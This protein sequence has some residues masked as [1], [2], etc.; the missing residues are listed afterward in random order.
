[1]WDQQAQN[2]FE[3]LLN[4]WRAGYRRLLLIY[5]GY[6]H[7]GKWKL[8]YAAALL[9]PDPVTVGVP[10]DIRISTKSLMAGRLFLDCVELD[11]HP[12]L[13][14]LVRGTL[15]ID[16]KH[17]ELAGAGPNDHSLNLFL[18]GPPNIPSQNV[19]MPTLVIRS[20]ATSGLANDLHIADV[21]NDLR[22]SD[23]PFDGFEDL[24]SSLGFPADVRNSG[25]QR[26][27]IFLGLAVV[28]TLPD[29]RIADSKAYIRLLASP[30]ITKTRV[31][32]GIRFSDGAN[33]ARRIAIA[34]DQLAW[35]TMDQWLEGTVNIP[36]GNTPYVQCL[37]QYG[38][39]HVSRWWLTDPSQHL[40]FRTAIQRAFDP[41]DRKLTKLLFPP[42]TESRDLEKGLALLM[43]IHGFG[44]LQ[45]GEKESFQEGPD[46][47]GIT[48]RG[49]ILVVECTVDLV[50]AHGKVTKLV[51]RSQ[52]ILESLRRANVSNIEVISVLATTLPRTDLAPH[53]E[54]FTKARVAVLAR[55][56]L[57]ESVRRMNFPANPDN[58]YD[59]VRRLLVPVQPA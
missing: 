28:L 42:K 15:D 39:E 25:S 29:S 16:G 45:Y 35:K 58:L 49:R 33:T 36:V 53:G 12:L 37:V 30:G 59:D 50:D 23:T 6:L 54:L 9:Q 38:G 14:A 27:E 13:Q 21:E 55:E 18:D 34:G 31:K 5:L 32:V 10:P 51:N 48:P 22:T 11:Q 40:N 52:K 7:E 47:I 1:M 24:I 3:T 26:I 43:G 4:R 20:K 46:L 17:L 2:R 44:V 57:E 8:V 41:E 19:R 56:D